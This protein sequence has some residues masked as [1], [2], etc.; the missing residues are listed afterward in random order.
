MPGKLIPGEKRTMAYKKA[1][2]APFK[3]KGSSFKQNGNGGGKTKTKTTTVDPYS[4]PEKLTGEGIHKDVIH[5]PEKRKPGAQPYSTTNIPSQF[6]EH[7]IEDY[8]KTNTT[9][10]KYGRP[11]ITWDDYAKN[12]AKEPSLTHERIQ[13]I[14][15]P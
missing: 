4:I 3:M 6:K 15:L 13:F 12:I 11:K 2:N 1:S 8:Q 7:Y 10:V 14:N 5:D 9:L